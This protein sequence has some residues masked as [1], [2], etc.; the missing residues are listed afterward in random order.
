VV[1]REAVAETTLAPGGYV[2]IEDRRYEAFCRSGLAPVGARLK[3]VGLDN[4]RLIV[5]KT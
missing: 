3:V 5:S 2:R 4:F 1:G